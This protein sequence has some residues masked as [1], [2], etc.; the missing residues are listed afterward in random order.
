MVGT[1]GS[2]GLR[3]GRRH[4]IGLDGAAID[5]RHRV[6]DLVAHVVDLAADQRVHRR[7]GAVEG[8]AGRLDVEDRIQ[9]LARHMRDRADAGMRRVDLALTLAFT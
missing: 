6:D 3:S 4:R 8:N 5:L 9:Q 7:T 2:D 1:S